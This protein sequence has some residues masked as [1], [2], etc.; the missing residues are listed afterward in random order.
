MLATHAGWVSL[1]VAAYDLL[2]EFVTRPLQQRWDACNRDAFEASNVKGS[3]AGAYPISFGTYH[4]QSEMR[5]RAAWPD[6]DRTH[7]ETYQHT[8]TTN[9]QITHKSLRKIHLNM[10]I[11]ERTQ[12]NTFVWSLDPDFTHATLKHDTHK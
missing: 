2:C 10:R 7:S 9:T 4:T 1:C 3:P 5:A 12:T 8:K 6:N 11:C